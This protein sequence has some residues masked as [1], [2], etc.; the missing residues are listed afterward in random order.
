MTCLSCGKD[1]P[2]FEDKWDIHGTPFKCP[3]C[4]YF[5]ELEWEEWLT[6]EGDDGC[7]SVVPCYKE[8]EDKKYYKCKWEEWFDDL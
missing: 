1:L 7:F 5:M 6:D 4:G 8:M 3:H 2:D